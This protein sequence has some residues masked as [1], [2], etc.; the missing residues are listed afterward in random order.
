MF[1]TLNNR[2]FGLLL[3][4]LCC[5]F[6]SGSGY[7]QAADSLDTE[8]Q[9]YKVSDEY[10]YGY[11]K[12]KLFDII[13]YVPSDLVG[14]GEFIIQKEN[15]AWV[16]G[17]V[18]A[19]LA[20]IPFDQKLLDNAQ[21]LGEPIG[22]SKDVRYIRVA[23]VELL[24]QDI[25]GAIY[26]LGNGLTPILIGIGLYTAGLINNDYRAMNTASEL[27][28]VM[29]SSGIPIQLIKRITGRQSPSAA[30]TSGIDGGHWTPFPSFSA[31]QSNTPEYDAI[32]SGHLSTLMATVTV[33]ATNYPEVKWIKPVGYS[34]MA[35]MGFQM[36]S[37]RVHWASDYPIALLIGYAIGK[38]AASRR[39]TK[40]LNK[41]V[42]KRKTNYRTNFTYASID[43]IRTVGFNITF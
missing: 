9:Y 2:S 35:V 4:L 26:Y 39:I 28:E 6:F 41:E 8:I 22:L 27:G 19:T 34:I 13:K 29:I 23:G 42:S 12:P 33:I 40:K 31:Y 5:F 30:I 10:S 37:T 21:E 18:G 1:Q 36:M 24:P 16:A 15:T 32:P 17:A 3:S 20:L 38:K 14:F 25:N 7:S 43:G 11:T